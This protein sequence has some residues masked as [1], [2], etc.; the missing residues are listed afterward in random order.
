M[1][2]AKSKH[3]SESDI[4]PKRTQEI[5]TILCELL[6]GNIDIPRKIVGHL[7]DA[8]TEWSRHWHIQRY[9][10]LYGTLGG[11]VFRGFWMEI[12]PLWKPHTDYQDY[13]IKWRGDFMNGDIATGCRQMQRHSA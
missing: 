7:K 11:I 13:N 12:R 8:E 3:L 6:D 5:A 10:Y 4:H 1:T 9:R 2:N